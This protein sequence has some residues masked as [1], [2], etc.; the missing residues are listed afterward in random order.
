MIA[1]RDHQQYTYDDPDWAEHVRELQ[2][3]AKTCG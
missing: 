3:A 1:N 2:A